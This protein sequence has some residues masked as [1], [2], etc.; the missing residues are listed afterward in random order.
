MKYRRLQA[1]FA[2]VAFG[3]ALGTL[4]S[5][6]CNLL[7]HKPDEIRPSLAQALTDTDLFHENPTDETIA[8]IQSLYA[9]KIRLLADKG[10]L[11]TMG[12]RGKCT[13]DASPDAWCHDPNCTEQLPPVNSPENLRSILKPVMKLRDDALNRLPEIFGVKQEQRKYVFLMAASDNHY[14]EAQQTIQSLHEKVFPFISNFS[15]YFYD[16]GLKKEQRDMVTTYGKAVVKTYPFRLLPSRIQF[17]KGYSWKP[18]MIQAHINTAEFVIYMDASVVITNNLDKMFEKA[19]YTGFL[20][21]PGHGSVAQHTSLLMFSYYGDAPCTFS[22]YTEYEGGFL[23]F[24]NEPFALKLLLEPWVACALDPLCMC[25]KNNLLSCPQ[26]RQYGKCHRYDLSAMTIVL[27][28]LFR[29]RISS[30]DVR[31]GQFHTIKQGRTHV[32][33]YLEHLQAANTLQ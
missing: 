8:Y 21:C 20:M 5:P 2:S 14:V 13:K 10:L 32:F 27:I 18:L 29:D 33:Q 26:K 28:K 17:L 24:R 4:F 1:G 16:I 23:V 3:F 6:F 12:R 11:K 15:F 7:N 31:R 30:F 25:P 22:P 9:E 19:T